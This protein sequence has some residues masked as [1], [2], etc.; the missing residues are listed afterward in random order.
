MSEVIIIAAVA[1]N[2]VIGNGLKIPWYISTDFRHFKE[3]TTGHTV[4]MGDR[5]WES[6]PVKPLPNRKNLVLSF[7]RSFNAEGAKVCFS[8][9][10]A[11]ELSKN[12]EKVFLIG[13][14]SVYQAGMTIADTLEL[15]RI[16]NDYQ[17]DVLFPEFDSSIWEETGREDHED[18]EHGPYSFITY[19]RR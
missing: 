9:E 10:E 11:L 14:A 6:L 5:T 4:I 2:N 7:D 8:M 18:Q 17:G 19:R 16:H 15:T 3:L 1:K 13:G 12:S